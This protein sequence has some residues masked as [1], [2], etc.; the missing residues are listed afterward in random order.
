VATNP[1][2]VIIAFE[3]RGDRD[4]ARAFDTIEARMLRFEKNATRGAQA[5]GNDRIASAK[6]EGA[7]REREASRISKATEK[8]E[9]DATKSVERES[10]QREKATQREEARRE[11][12]IRQ[13]SA[14][15]GRLAKQQ[16]DEE[17]RQQQ[18]ATAA[19][20]REVSKRTAAY[21]KQQRAEDR[22]GRA[23][24]S[25]VA[26]VGS[27]SVS[28]VLGGA[29]RLVGSA[30]AIGGGLSLADSVRSDMG[31]DTAAAHLANS[32]TIEGKTPAGANVKAIV[33]RARAVGA[34][35]GVDKTELIGAVQNYVAKSADFE[36]G[37][38]N[39]DFFA[40][41][42][43]GSG[44]K[45][46]DITGAAGI[47]RAQ[48]KDLA[49][50][51]MRQMLLDMTAQG[52]KGAVEI[53][54]MAALAGTLGSTRSLFAG[55]Q[56]DN[57]R[58]L[59]GLAQLT[60]PEVGSADEAAMAVKHIGESATSPE[61]KKALKALGVKYKKNAAGSEEIESIEQLIESSLTGSKG[62]LGQLE[63]TFGERGVKVFQHLSPLFTKAGG[64]KAGIEAVR[65]EMEPILSVRGT[66]E[67]MQGEFS[68]VMKTNGEQLNLA[69]LRIRDAI[70]QAAA[71]ALEKLVA[72]LPQLIPEIEKLVTGVANVAEW[73]L[74][75]PL[76]GLG[77]VV[78][79]NVTKDLAGAGIG[80]AV[81]AAL[82]AMMSGGG[83]GGIA[84]GAGGLG[85]A[86]GGAGAG[87]TLGAVALG[88]VAGVGGGVA[89]VDY[90]DKKTK[91]GQTDDLASQI[92]QSNK[93]SLR[94]VQ[95]QGGPDAGA[96]RA[97]VMST[98]DALTKQKDDASRDLEEKK[99]QIGG[100]T[101]AAG[102]E[103]EGIDVGVGK[104]QEE[105]TKAAQVKYDELQARITR[106]SEAMGLADTKIRNAAS[107]TAD[108]LDG[109][110]GRFV[111][112]KIT[113]VPPPG[114]NRG[115]PISARP[116]Q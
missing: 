32:A 11:R 20:E 115:Q 88:A 62:D 64:G 45:L 113:E 99:K 95:M 41:L 48:N 101:G 111:G 82:T 40:K 84:G 15:A 110:R 59:I 4:V 24:G 35:T 8:S 2:P 103:F 51:D 91:K 13:S 87:A 30:L 9:R 86:A 77:A 14:M 74:A 55:N 71:P 81:K 106:L 43:K 80:A 83:V 79:L 109:L 36:G 100:G 53:S 94:A 78:L 107:G 21:Q 63:K 76:E 108:S 50:E 25:G 56:A 18:R 116:V 66:H 72:D 27:R 39:M 16:A 31:A 28:R 89:L 54:D 114:P 102:F 3:T 68:T 7:A 52:K 38:A 17:I 12:I 6:R 75:N 23:F 67:Q 47:L 42:S 26:G 37:M 98:I 60:R 105:A 49:P 69:F 97:D 44:A 1:D 22:A 96:A 33:D 57:Q 58:K 46:E 92:D 73:F 19:I 10:S 93:D 70:G 61:H 34:E 85:G 90:L 112:A 65:A 29:G 104:A 5:G